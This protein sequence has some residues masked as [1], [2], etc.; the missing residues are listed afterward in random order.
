MKK[1]YYQTP[2]GYVYQMVGGKKKRVS[3]SKVGGA[4]GVHIKSSKDFNDIGF[5]MAKSYIPANNQLHESCG[6][7]D[8]DSYSQVYSVYKTNDG[9]QQGRRSCG[10]GRT[11]DRMI[12]H[13]HPFGGKFYPSVED[14]LQIFDYEKK[15]ANG[16]VYIH[17]RTHHLAQS[18]I[19][20]T[21][22]GYW[23]IQKLN[24]TYAFPFKKWD[25]IQCNLNK[26]NNDF[27]GRTTAGR[28]YVADAIQWYTYNVQKSFL[29][30]TKNIPIMSL[31]FVYIP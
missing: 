5:H 31:Q 30:Y 28:H 12:W 29:H 15:L 7:I 21:Q 22:F 27:Y 11:Q 23:V 26:I 25:A 16:T 19:I 13:T 1:V 10:T 6:Y 9:N 3:A 20:F 4:P 2:R 14:L 24:N 18:S 17:E 8:Y